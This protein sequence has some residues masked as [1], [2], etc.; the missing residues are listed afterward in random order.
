MGHGASYNRP[1]LPDDEG[2]GLPLHVSAR[3]SRV[4]DRFREIA[5]SV[6]T[7]FIERGSYIACA[8]Q[9]IHSG[10]YCKRLKMFQPNRSHSSL[11][12]TL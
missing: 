8:C 1:A 7:V 5:E 6:R 10:E 12:G 9:D 4:S 3:I 2:Q 11:L